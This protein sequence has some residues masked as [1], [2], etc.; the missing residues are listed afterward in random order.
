MIE[1]RLRNR[2]RADVVEAKVGKVLAEDDYDILLSGPARILM[3]DGRPLCIYLPGAIRQVVAAAYPTLT[4]VRGLTDNRGHAAGSERINTGGARTRSRQ[5]ASTIAGTYDRADGG[6]DY[7][8]RLTAFNANQMESF[9]RLVPIFQ[10]IQPYFER[11]VP[12]RYANQMSHVAATDPDWIIPGTPFTTITIN[13]TYPTGVHQDKGDL[14]EG[15]SMLTCLKSGAWHGGHITFPE[16]RVAAPMNTGDLMMMDAHQWHAN[17]PIICDTCNE[18]IHRPGHKCSGSPG[19]VE[20]ISLVAY[21]RTRMKDCGSMAD[22]NTKRQDLREARN[23]TRV[24]G[25]P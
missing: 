14:D 11:H 6:H 17:T 7:T 18:H 25:E 16:F 4:K 8:C 24:G 22:E 5:V 13:H 12:D 19:E 10:A 20:R 9:E 3:P 21:Y 15:Y 1:L 2:V 23:L